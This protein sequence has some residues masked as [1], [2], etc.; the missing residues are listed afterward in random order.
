MQNEAW[1]YDE[2][3]DMGDAADEGDASAIEIER[4]V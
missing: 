4:V 2:E 1:D 3:E